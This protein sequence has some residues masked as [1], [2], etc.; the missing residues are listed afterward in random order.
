MVKEVSDLLT[1]GLI[2]AS[3]ILERGGAQAEAAEILRAAKYKAQTQRARGTRTAYE[4]KRRGEMVAS[5]ARAAMA[6]GGGTTTGAGAIS[7]LGKIG[8]ETDYNAL[9]ALYEGEEEARITMIEGKRQA[10]AAKRRGLSTLISGGA[11]IYKAYKS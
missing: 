1:M 7:T 8:T 2:G 6:A 3:T 4:E 11:G 10:K 9:A 5:D